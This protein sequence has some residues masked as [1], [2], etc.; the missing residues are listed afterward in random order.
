VAHQ[1]TADWHALVKS[2]PGSSTVSTQ[3]CRYLHYTDVL[4]GENQKVANKL[5]ITKK[6]PGSQLG[7]TQGCQQRTGLKVG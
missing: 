3:G 7:L 2:P 6:E 1:A 4:L 5:E